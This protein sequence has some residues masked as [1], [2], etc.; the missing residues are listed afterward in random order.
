MFKHLYSH[1]SIIFSK[2][3]GINGTSFLQFHFDHILCTIVTSKIY[4]TSVKQLLLRVTK[5]CSSGRMFS[6]LPSLSYLIP[7]ADQRGGHRGSG[8]PLKNH[9]NIGFLCNTGPDPQQNH[10]AIK[11]A[12]NGPSSDCQRNAILMAFR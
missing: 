7:W 3:I 4:Q 5:S 1:K 6:I 8:S 11:P 10:K 12:F 9:K 2:C